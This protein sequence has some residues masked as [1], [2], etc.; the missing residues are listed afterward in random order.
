MTSYQPGD[1]VLVDFPFTTS[2]PS[3]P[4]PALVILDTGD[5]DVLLARVTTQS[6]NTAFDV[7]IA[8]WQQAGLLAPSTVRLHKLATLAKSRV[9]RQL[10]TLLA[11][12][13]QHITSVLQQI[14]AN[15]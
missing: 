2:G 9:R 11:S 10:G 8:G 7:P 3:K 4:R 1:L 6:Q 5:A 13:R 14:A 15:W 12:D